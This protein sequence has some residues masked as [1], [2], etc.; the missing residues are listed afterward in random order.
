[1]HNDTSLDQ[2]K[3]SRARSIRGTTSVGDPSAPSTPAQ[4]NKSDRSYRLSL[5][6]AR[7]LSRVFSDFSFP[8]SFTPRKSVGDLT[9]Q[10]R[11]S[12]R[13]STSP[14]RAQNTPF[15]GHYH[16]IQSLDR[17][18]SQAMPLP[19]SPIPLSPITPS[20]ITI[21][22]TPRSSAERI[23]QCY[24]LPTNIPTTSHN[25]STSRPEEIPLPPSR[26]GSSRGGTSLLRKNRKSLELR[27]LDEF[28]FKVPLPT[29]S[30]SFRVLRAPELSR[31]ILAKV[32][33]LDGGSV[34]PPDTRAPPRAAPHPYVEVKRARKMTQVIIFWY[35]KVAILLTGN[36]RASFLDR[37][38]HKS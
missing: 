10:N 24:G 26:P 38:S 37:N 25:K 35:L 4:N 29:R 22:P 27:P 21:F 12:Q 2:S 18:P 8:D 5:S 32:P 11:T 13:P 6:K 14:G 34:P 28:G 17:K 19:P 36:F 23:P 31:P 30:K 16:Y 3:P 15:E 1:M 7:K 33:N 20:S 9:V